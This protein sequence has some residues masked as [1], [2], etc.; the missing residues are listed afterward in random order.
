MDKSPHQLVAA[1]VN[2]HTAARCMHVVADFGVADA[3]QDEPLS[4]AE[5]ARRTG[6]NA[7]ALSRMLRLLAAHGVFAGTSEAYTHTPASRLLRSDHPQSMRGLA[8]TLGMPS[9]WD[10]LTELAV[11]A[12]TGKPARDWASLVAYYADH[13]DEAALFNQAMVDKSAVVVPAVVAAHDFTAYKLIADIA[14]G[15]AHLLQG[16][17][18]TVPGATGV[19][20][21]MPHVIADAGAIASSRL[22]LQAGNF[23]T[24]ALPV[25]DAYLLMDVIHDWNDVDAAR[26]LAAIRKAAPRHAR[27]LIVESLIGEGPGN[28]N[29]KMLDI[30]MLAVTG[31]RERSPPEFR[32]LLEPAGFRIERVVPTSSAYSVLEASVA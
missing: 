31:G 8:R 13:R 17:L 26:I 6:L 23:F 28:L 32:A 9:L 20:F 10:G 30:V 7:D 3:L 14:G 29:G 19:L 11:A 16:I 18:A 24:D 1:L 5:L 2:A 15:R 22:K 12:K 4:G 25:A 21:E 27:L